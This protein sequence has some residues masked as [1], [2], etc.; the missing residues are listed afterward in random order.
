MARALAVVVVDKVT[1]ERFA[2]IQASAAQQLGQALE[3]TSGSISAHGVD[4]DYA[5]VGASTLT[6]TVTKV[7]T[8]FGHPLVSPGEVQQKLL[9]W[10]ESVQ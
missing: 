7:P 9:A 2:R 5:Y 4:V 8:I 6:L 1:P 10:V 3:G